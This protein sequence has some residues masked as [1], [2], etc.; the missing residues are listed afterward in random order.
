MN[1][2]RRQCLNLGLVAGLG[3]VLA[4]CS[5]TPPVDPDVRTDVIDANYKAADALLEGLQLDRKQPLLVATFVN[6]E[7]LTESSRLGRLFS[8]LVGSRLAQRGYLVKELKLRESLFMKQ[9]QGALLLSR[10]VREISQTQEAQAVIVGTYT[11]SSKMLY[12]SVKLV[13]PEGNVV[14]SAHDY[15]MPLDTNIKGLLR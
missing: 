13:L 11:Q 5:S 6:L 12:L 8:E 4:A 3:A 1:H 15:A 9:T 2:A 10:E 14:L 7:V